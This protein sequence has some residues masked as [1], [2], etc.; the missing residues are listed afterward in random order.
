MGAPIHT[1]ELTNGPNTDDLKFHWE[2]NGEILRNGEGQITD[3]VADDTKK[4]EFQGSIRSFKAI[5][6]AGSASINGTSFRF[7]DL[8]GY[9]TR[10]GVPREDKPEPKPEPEPEPEPEGSVVEQA[11]NAL[12]NLIGDWD[13][14]REP[15]HLL[16]FRSADGEPVDYRVSV[17][18]ELAPTSENGATHDPQDSVEREGGDWTARGTVAG[19]L[20]AYRYGGSRLVF[21]SDHPEKLEARVNEKEW[22][23]AAAYGCVQKSPDGGG[24]SA[25]KPRG[26]DGQNGVAQAKQ[27]ARSHGI[28]V[29]QVKR[30][31]STSELDGADHTLNYAPDGLDWDGPADLGSV[32]NVAVIGDGELR[33]PAGRRAYSVIAQGHDFLWAGID[34]NQEAPGAWGRVRAPGARMQVRDITFVGRGR[35]AN[36]D[37]SSGLPGG[38]AGAAIYMPAKSPD[39]TNTIEGVTMVHGGVLA[40]QHFGDRPTGV[41]LAGRHRGTLRIIDTEIS[42]VPNNAIYAT[43]AP[44][45]VEIEGC[46][47]EDNGV[48]CGG[49]IAHGYWKNCQIEYDASRDGLDNADAPEHGVSA[50]GSEQKKDGANGKPGPD[51][52]NCSVTV[53]NVGKGGTGLRAYDIHRDAKWGVIRDTDIH[54]EDGAGDWAADIELR[55]VVESIRNCEFSGSKDSYHSIDNRSGR[56][57]VT[58]GCDWDYPSGR[59]RSKGD[60]IDWQ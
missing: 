55:G 45:R 28:D 48:M 36:P 31:E 2:V 58:S 50:L 37:P 27:L 21:E 20:D 9:D 17:S 29:K 12:G 8:P 44:G 14:D 42:S 49:R 41:F 3:N 15:P 6:G 30:V 5:R 56:R 18:K 59:G 60:P 35:R 43:A 26:P 32:S 57:V 40:D 13:F 24:S 33:V 1:L 51:V 25:D 19:G 39:A 7:Q 46:T 11:T 4:Y 10:D 22:Q 53:T 38:T 23:S 16:E 54:I 47:F 52:I 34:L